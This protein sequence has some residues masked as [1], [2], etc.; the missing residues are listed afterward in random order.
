MLPTTI[1]T[2]LETVVDGIL[3]HFPVSHAPARIPAT[4]G[5]GLQRGWRPRQVVVVV[6]AEVVLVVVVLVVVVL[7]D[8]GEC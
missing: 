2:N 1:I 7:V 5:T 8:I 6:A 4:N 3:F